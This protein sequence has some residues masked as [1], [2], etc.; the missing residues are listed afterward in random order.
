MTGSR[1]GH[2]RP[3]APEGVVI[4]GH[5]AGLFGVH[6]WVKVYSH[7]RP[8]EAI[9]AYNPWLVKQED[10]WQERAF[11]EGRLQGKG[12]VAHL[13]GCT[14]RDQAGRLIGSE[15][16]VRVEQLPALKQ[17]EYYWAQLEGLKVVN[18]AGQELGTVSH[19]FET[20]GANDVMVVRGRRER[21]V[22][23]IPSVI[24]KVDLEAGVIHVDW[25]PEDGA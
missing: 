20:G 14:D 17:G 15:I 24:R 8:R 6:G 2:S 10:L 22:P 21:L 9:L 19:L 25:E 5:V 23:F 3:A 12:I 18:R 11:L 1:Q 7:T 16:A 4:V 13:A